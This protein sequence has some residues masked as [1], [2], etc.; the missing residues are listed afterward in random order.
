MKKLLL[1]SM[2]SVLSACASQPKGRVAT[3][4]LPKP[5]PLSA[6]VSRAMQPNSTD[7]LKKV[8]AWLASSRQLLDN[9][10]SN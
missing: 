8:E 6:E 1:L 5:A 7:L 3:N 4:V 2:L 9:A 10:N